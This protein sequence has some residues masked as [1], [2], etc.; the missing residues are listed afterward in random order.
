MSATAVDACAAP[1][2]QARHRMHCV[3]TILKYGTPCL[4]DIEALHSDGPGHPCTHRPQRRHSLLNQADLNDRVVMRQGVEVKIKDS[5][6]NDVQSVAAEPVLHLNWA[7]LK[8]SLL[9]GARAVQ[10]AV[11]KHVDHGGDVFTMKGRDDGSPAREG[12][13]L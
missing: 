11:A 2:C 6:A 12:H 13:N 10:G 1:F 9:K 3:G 4:S 8:G 5:L 7:P